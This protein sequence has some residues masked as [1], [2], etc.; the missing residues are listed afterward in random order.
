MLVA[1]QTGVAKPLISQTRRTT[2][3]GNFRGNYPVLQI[4]QWWAALEG[5]TL[6]V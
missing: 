2:G 3:K 1:G 4:P 5:Q 6:L